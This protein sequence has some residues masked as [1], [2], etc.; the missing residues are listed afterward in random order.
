[1]QTSGIVA[2]V[3]GGAS[4]LGEATVRR[5]LNSDAAHVVI[6]DRNAE[7]GTALAAA[8]GDA[9]SFITCD[10]TDETAVKAAV[11]AATDRGPLRLAVNC[12]GVGFAH[13]TIKRD[14]T[15]HPLDIFKTVI[16]V[17]LFGTFNLV[18]FAA[19]A[20]SQ[21]EPLEG[22]R[23]VIVNTASVAAFDGQI[24]QIAYAASKGAI[25][26]MTLPAARDLSKALIRVMTIAPGLFDTPLLASLPEAARASLAKA[27]PNP[28]RLGEPAEFAHLVEAIFNNPYLNGE[29]IRLDGSLRMQPK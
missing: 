23:G 17:N 19:S 9:A 6:V 26:G 2:L 20:M 10:V 21:Q 28:A 22:E 18:R 5:L 4:G 7:K 11:Q 25:V 15:P 29:T 24:G 3:S 8:L 12:A 14:G 16:E 27:I 13:R 1:M